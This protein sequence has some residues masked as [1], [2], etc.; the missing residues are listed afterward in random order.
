[1][2]IGSKHLAPASNQAHESDLS[3]TSIQGR[4]KSDDKQKRFDAAWDREQSELKASWRQAAA[5]KCPQPAAEKTPTDDEVVS[6]AIDNL[7][8]AR[9]TWVLRNQEAAA[10]QAL[11]AK[12]A[13][14]VEHEQFCRSTR[15]LAENGRRFL[16]GSEDLLLQADLQ[17]MAADIRA[18]ADS[19]AA[20]RSR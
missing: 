17:A 5:A 14:T 10:R 8:H 3:Q 18:I 9:D 12:W 1:V 20:I 15:V 7:R 19:A 4:S 6:Q 11:E 2:K 16:P 13:Q